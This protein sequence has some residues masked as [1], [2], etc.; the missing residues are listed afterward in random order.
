PKYHFRIA[1]L[2]VDV[3]SVFIMIALFQ[4]TEPVKTILSKMISVMSNVVKPMNNQLN[5]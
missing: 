5:E 4:F 2:F 1:Y 3:S